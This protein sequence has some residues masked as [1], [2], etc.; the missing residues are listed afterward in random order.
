[1][2][3]SFDVDFLDTDSTDFT[4]VKEVKNSGQGYEEYQIANSK[5]DS[6]WVI[7]RGISQFGLQSRIQG[8][9]I[10]YVT[11]RFLIYIGLICG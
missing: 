2:R 9:I 11:N 3:F 1:M 8:L 5:N 7:S 4:E 6:A 10:R